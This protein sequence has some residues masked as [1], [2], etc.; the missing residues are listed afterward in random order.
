MAIP[1]SS[2][3]KINF[4]GKGKNKIKGWVPKFSKTPPSLSARVDGGAE[5]YAQAGVEVT[6]KG[7]GKSFAVGLDMKMPYIRADFSALSNSRGV[8]GTRRT[9]GV[10]LDATVGANLIA[11]ASK[12]DKAFWK[13]TL[14]NKKLGTL[15]DQC[16]AFGPKN[17]KKPRNE[18]TGE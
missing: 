18:I 12:N 1:N 4:L 8:C 16:Y 5:A 13:K 9:L 10:D 15:I 17:A 11:S 6:A 2:I 14:F 7:L 3:L